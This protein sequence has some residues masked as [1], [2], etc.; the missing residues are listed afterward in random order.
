[1]KGAL[2]NNEVPDY[3]TRRLIRVYTVLN[4]EV[5]INMVIIKTNLIPPLLE[6]DLLK[7]LMLKSSLGINWV[8]RLHNHIN[9]I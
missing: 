5:S 3:R 2:A 9:D 7:E 4:T 6:M 8:N 1:M